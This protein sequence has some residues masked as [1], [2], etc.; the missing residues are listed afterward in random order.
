ME[1]LGNL[2][3]DQ[4]NLA[5][6]HCLFADFLNTAQ[7]LAQ[8]DAGNTERQRN[9]W[10]LHWRMADLLE[11]QND[12]KAMFHWRKT[13]NILEGMVKAG[14]PVSQQDLEFLNR[15]RARLGE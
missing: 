3:V 5:E 10:V 13:H 15:L 8:A 12:P 6:A 4:G 7:R 2:A 14:Q 11:R 9:L 1:N